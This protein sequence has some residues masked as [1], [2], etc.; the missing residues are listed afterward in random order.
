MRTILFTKLNKIDSDTTTKKINF[1]ESADQLTKENEIFIVDDNEANIEAFMD[2]TDQVYIPF[3][4]LDRATAKGNVHVYFELEQYPFF[5]KIK[6][7]ITVPKGVLHFKRTISTAESTQLI[8]SDLIVFSAILG[9]PVD[10]KVKQTNPTVAPHHQIVTVNF[11]EG[12]MAH[13]EYT[14]GKADEKIE[15]EWSGIKQIIEFDSEEM[16]PLVPGG[17]TSLP[18]TFSVDSILTTAVKADEKLLERL[19]KFT[20]LITGGAKV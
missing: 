14:I 10:V 13:L 19:Q 2:E 7:A 4:L 11:G 12:T 3:K 6:D 15:L 20:Q 18:L 1:V 5:Q 9:E 8:A 16:K 17:Y